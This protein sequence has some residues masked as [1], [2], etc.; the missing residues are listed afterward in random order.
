MSTHRPAAHYHAAAFAL[1]LAASLAVFAQS[2]NDEF[3][4]LDDGQYLFAN[5]H[6]SADFSWDN[7]RWA[8]TD[9]SIANWHPVTLLSHVFMAAAFGLDPQPHHIANITL[10]AINCALLYAFLFRMTGGFW[11]SLVATLLFAVH[12]LRVESVA[13]VSERKGL[14]CGFFGLLTLLAY[15]RYSRAPS[16]AKYLPVLVAFVLGLLSKPALIPLPFALLL[17]DY[18]PLNRFT[19]SPLLR[20][21]I[22]R[23]S[24]RGAGFGTKQSPQ[25][26]APTPTTQLPPSTLHLLTEKIP[27]IVLAIA[28]TSLT[29]IAQSSTGTVQSVDTYPISVR[30]ANAIVSY[31]MYL[32]NTFVPFHLTLHY[33]HLRDAIFTAPAL[34]I[35]GAAIVLISAAALRQSRARPWLIVGWLWFLG[36]LLPAIGL[37]QLADQ[38]RADRYTYLPQIGLL[39]IVAWSLD[40]LRTRLPAASKVLSGGVAAAIAALAVLA[41]VQTTR[42]R[43]DYTLF[44]H[45]VAESPASSQAHYGLGVAYIK[46]G[47]LDAAERSF[48]DSIARH[49]PVYQAYSNLGAIELRRGSFAK[50]AEYFE[51]ALA[52]EGNDPE[53]L[54]NLGVARFNLGLTAEA[55]KLAEAALAIEPAH[56]RALELRNACRAP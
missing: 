35:S 16:F 31:G 14:L 28:M 30:I 12:P 47:D 50:A 37:V 44:T 19:S 5:S 20:G 24:L 2:A 4:S 48:L 42:W 26:V 22:P 6:I 32:A 18:W 17:L 41:F 40:E 23:P 51:A 55:L 39:I 49:P 13:W 29:Y 38:A 9:L 56:P 52:I 1:I 8:L 46:R 27:L 7:V 54:V 21:A 34:Y 53:L 10:H 36:M 43:D 45:A 25:P 11:P 33:T 3:I 15:E